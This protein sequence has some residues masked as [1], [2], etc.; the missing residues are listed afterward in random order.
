MMKIGFLSYKINTNTIYFGK[1]CHAKLLTTQKSKTRLSDHMTITSCIRIH[2]DNINNFVHT[3]PSIDQGQSTVLVSNQRMSTTSRNT[4]EQY[5]Q[6]S[7]KVL[8]SVRHIIS[9][10]LYRWNNLRFLSKNFYRIH[11]LNRS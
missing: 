5:L 10:E 3:P 1:T 11:S 4:T 6:S 2:Y 9:N 8:Y 7:I